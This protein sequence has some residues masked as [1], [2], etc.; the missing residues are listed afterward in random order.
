MTVL[1]SLFA[2]EQRTLTKALFNKAVFEDAHVEAGVSVDQEKALRLIAVNRCI[3]LQA[4]TVASLPVDRYK[5][6]SDDRLTLSRPVWMERPN[7]ETSWFKFVERIVSCHQTDGNA[8]ILTSGYDELALPQELWL[9]DPRKVD[10][11]RDDDNGLYYEYEG[12]E[13]FTPYNRQGAR[14][15]DVLHV[16]AF[17]YP[18]SLRG[19]SP[20]DIA[21]E[22]IGL[23]LAAEKF[24]SRFF[25]SGQHLSG[26][27]E[28]PGSPKQEAV[29]KLRSNWVARHS[30]SNKSHMP[31]VLTAGATWKPTSISPEQAQFLES[32]KFQVSEIARLFG[33]PPHL[34][35]DV[36]K[37]T[38][39]G[40]GIEEQN[41]Q[42]LNLSLLPQ[43][44]RVEEALNQ[45][46]PRG[47]FVK[48]N[49]AGFLRADI[50][51]RYESYGLLLDRGVITGNEVRRLEDL[52]SLEGLDTPRVPL[53]TTTVGAEEDPDGR[54]VTVQPRFNVNMP[55]QRM[56]KVEVHPPSVTV[57]PP[58]V[59]VT[60]EPAQVHVEPRMVLESKPKRIQVKENGKAVREYT[61]V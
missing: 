46:V 24:G 13:K 57:N 42:W 12:G 14:R 56:P 45:F 9:L 40:S 22:G 52:N 36:E 3:R 1:R 30:G 15:G 25:G 6:Q 61:E 50:K 7:P 5:V 18:G 27:I 48:F 35:G 8:F 23:G 53:N 49:L 41:R 21:R 26:V 16:P 38:S 10:I 28:V 19:L 54:S 59:N 60:V 55:E 33:V 39:W 11:K 17:S 43:I 31:G 29:D 47:Q 20:I 37:S 34:I 51:T 4:E 32:R 44:I 2:G 58:E